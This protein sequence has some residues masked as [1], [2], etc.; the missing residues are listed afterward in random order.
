MARLFC[1]FFALSLACCFFPEQTIADTNRA[2]SARAWQSDDGLPDNSVT[3][4]AQT[5]DG[6]LWIATHNGLARF[7][8]VQFQQIKLPLP[9]G[10]THPLIRAMTLGQENE[11]WFAVEGGLVISASSSRTNVFTAANGLPALRP[12]SIVEDAAGRAW[13]SY[14]DGSV[15]EISAKS[16]K[17]STDSALPDTGACWLTGDIKGQLWFARAGEV[18]V[19][20]NDKFETLLKLPQK[21]LHLCASREGGVWICDGVR[22]LKYQEG[23][24]M[25]DC[26]K[27]PLNR[28]TDVTCLFED[29][30]GAVWVGTSGNG[31][32]RYD[33]TQLTR[34]KTLR[35]EIYCLAED[36]E[37]NLWVGTGGGGLNRLRPKIVELQ[38]VESGLPSSTVLSTCEDTTGSIW[39]ATR[40]GELT[41][42]KDGQW[43]TFP[44]SSD[45]PNPHATC[46]ASD[47]RGGVWIGTYHAGLYHW[48]D[49]H[50]DVI[51]RKDGLAG[52]IVRGL[53][54]DHAGDLWIALE[55]GFYLQKLHDGRLQ[56][57]AQPGGSRGI[58]ALAEDASNHV[59]CG[60]WNG[61]LLQ[62]QGDALVNKT[63]ETLSE[64][65]PILSLL[66]T[67][68]GDLWI[69]YADAGLGFLHQGHF[70]VFGIE[71]GLFDSRICGVLADDGGGIWCSSDHGIFQLRIHDLENF[72]DGHS[73]RLNCVIFGH[74]EG[75]SNLEGSY[76]YSPG[77]MRSGD[78]RLWFPMRTGLAVVNPA[79][80]PASHVPPPVLIESVSVDGHNASLENAASLTI[81]PNHHQLD[82]K[83]TALSFVVPENVR[84][85]YRLEGWD[86]DWVE[87]KARFADYSRLPAGNYTFHVIACNN[88]G[89]WNEKGARLK[90]VVRPFPWQ[91]WWFRAG[92]LIVFSLGLISLVRYISFRRLHLKLARLEKEAVVQKERARIAKDIHDDLG[93][94]LTQISLVGKLAQQDLAS[95]EKA[96]G[97]I[98]QISFIARQGIKSVDEIVWAA[99][100][101][102][103]TLPHLLNYSGQFAV[104]FL[105]AADIRCRVDFPDSLPAR[106]L[107][108]DVRHSLFLVV[109]EALNNAVKHSGATEIWLKAELM[110]NT[111]CLSVEDDGHGFNQMPDDAFGGDGLRNMRQRLSEIGG[112]CVVESN[113]GKGTC[114]RLEL[115]LP[116]ASELNSLGKSMPHDG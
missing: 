50:F 48:H 35:E 44:A 1:L 39:A 31:L 49:N 88:A 69:G 65:K 79:H 109:K 77:A 86:N 59:W 52:D 74:D 56:T 58:C 57:F 17:W 82:V 66:A 45:W 51:A 106:Q 19:F 112:K 101:R 25:A 10:R 75:L 34:V 61:Y 40:N 53:L 7:D 22:L 113:P 91:T 114:V 102:N 28:E 42:L 76:G 18:G 89:V 60:T 71:D 2:W 26:G 38:S 104:D 12:L 67:P 27:I 8:G 33:G 16:K 84:F 15:F 62:V 9:S 63:R 95:P 111:L 6:Y 115:E 108:A 36:R 93:A 14:S 103:D 97:H 21:I 105:R 87:T 73:N 72:A 64:L 83:F 70:T 23:G 30:S 37:D 107:A 78:G 55:S 4:V 98:E 94:S 85:R 43:K 116:P 81:P 80:V 11:L 41:R 13:V 100:P 3:G 92:V 46:V 5:S 90:F 54:T 47:G 29:H 99:N 20:R 110:G 32:F 24:N 68:D 96:R